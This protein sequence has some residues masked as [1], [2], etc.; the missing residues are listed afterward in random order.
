LYSR[1]TALL[2]IL[3]ALLLALPRAVLGFFIVFIGVLGVREGGFSPHTGEYYGA[4]L[5]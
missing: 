4:Q 2:A 5:N 3:L 1:C